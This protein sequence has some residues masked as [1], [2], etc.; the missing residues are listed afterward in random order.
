[1]VLPNL[2]AL[3][4]RTG[5][6]APQ[7]LPKSFRVWLADVART[8]VVRGGLDRSDAATVVEKEYSWVA[9]GILPD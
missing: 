2:S 8:E 4:P 3:I 1:L 9:K 6:A 7:R 5:C